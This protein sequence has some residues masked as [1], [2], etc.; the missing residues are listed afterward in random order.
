VARRS[1]P[2]YLRRTRYHLQSGGFAKLFSV[3][4][5]KLAKFLPPGLRP[6]L[7][8]G[9]V[10]QLS[11][12]SRFPETLALTPPSGR[13]NPQSLDL[14]WL[15]A[16][17][18]EGSG[19]H[20]TIFRTIQFLEKSGHKNTLWLYEPSK[21]A[22]E[23]DAR[24]AIQEQFLPLQAEVRFLSGNPAQIQGDAV[25]ATHWWSAYHARAVT[26]VRE[27][28]YFVQDFEP[29]FYPMG[30]EYLLAENTYRFGY[31]CICASRWLKSLMTERFGARR[32]FSFELAFDPAFYF[33]EPKTQRS[34]RRVAFYSR[35]TTERRAVELGLLALTEAAKKVPNLH[36]DFFGYPVG[37]LEVTFTYTDHGI[38]NHAEL[39]KLYREAAV[40]LVFS[41][42]NYSLIGQEMMACGLPV[43]DLD[44]ENTRGA[45]AP[46]SV[47]LA[48]PNPVAIAAK[49][50]ELLTQESARLAVAT[51]GQSAVEKL[52]WEKS[53]REIEAA[54]V[55]TL[56]PR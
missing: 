13:A 15:I 5:K 20:M 52:S 41:A 2:F 9:A 49:I 3:A 28:F 27:R 30:S 11:F 37:K 14:H 10:S 46:D 39:A 21:Y 4:L 48:Q 56:S 6:N 24:E 32:A 18:S 29:S 22:T 16:M 47:V 40:G 19:G 31:A 38:L 12:I 34:A 35:V 36:V 53:A 17:F 44:G 54:L 25:I 8:A 43:I 1:I 51:R 45:Y 33:A 42:T 55:E 26:Q 23:A 7:V 50:T